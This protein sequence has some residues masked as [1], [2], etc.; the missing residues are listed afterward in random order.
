VYLNAVVRNFVS[1]FHSHKMASG[2]LA[3]FHSIIIAG[4]HI[5]DPFG[6]GSPK[7]LPGLNHAGSCNLYLRGYL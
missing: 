1:I 5:T 2:L 6:C 7:L 3:V 4:I